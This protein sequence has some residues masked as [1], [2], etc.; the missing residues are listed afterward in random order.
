MSS[1]PLS[2]KVLAT[3][4]QAVL[5][6]FELVKFSDNP[7][8]PEIQVFLA[9][10]KHALYLVR[11]NLGGLYPSDDNGA[12][13]FAHIEHI[14]EDSR[15]ST[16]L[17]V[18]LTEG[19][20]STW[21]TKQLYISCEHRHIL[22]LHI[23]V[24]WS[25]DYTFRY[26]LP[27]HLHLSKHPLRRS[28]K[29]PQLRLKPFVGCRYANVQGYRFFMP[30]SFTDEENTGM[31]EDHHRQV[32]LHVDVHE[33][34]P[35]G[36]LEAADQDHIR[37]IALEYKQS[38][39]SKMN[40]VSMSRNALYHKR[41]NL[42]NDLCAW[43]GWEVCIKSDS[44]VMSSILLRRQYVPPLCDTAQDI[45]IQ[46]KCPRYVLDEGK[47]TE[48]ELMR[49]ASLI[50]DSFSASTAIFTQPQLVYQDFIQARLDALLYSED[51]LS[52]L[53]SSLSLKPAIEAEARVFTKSCLKVMA[54]ESQLPSPELVNA[55]GK[56]VDSKT[57]PLQV[58]QAVLERLPHLNPKEEPLPHDPV[59]NSWLARV[60]RYFA[61]CLDGVFLPSQFTLYDM[62]MSKLSNKPNKV[63]IQEALL[64]MLHIRP[65]DLT[66]P[67]K[68]L[69]I[70]QLLLTPGFFQDYQF[71]DLVMQATLELGW[72]AKQFAEPMG[73]E[74]LSLEFTVFLAKLLVSDMSSVNLKTAICR[75]I[76][77]SCSGPMHLSI[78][79]PAIMSILNQRNIHLKTYGTVTLV[80]M[81]AAHE[82]VKDLIL[83]MN[84]HHSLV[85]HLQFRDDDLVYYTLTLLANMSKTTTHRLILSQSGVVEH[86]TKLLTALPP[87]P[88]KHR[89]IAELAGTL[90]QFANDEDIWTKMTS[91]R[92]TFE[93]IQEL[94]LAAPPGTRMRSRIMFVLRQYCNR[95][96]N[97]S[98]KLREDVGQA[99]PVLV[100]DLHNLVESKKLSHGNSEA[101]DCAVNAVLLLST[102]SL[103]S[104]LCKE[105]RK[106]NFQPVLAKLRISPLYKLDATREKLGKLWTQLL[107][108]PKKDAEPGAT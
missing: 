2:L 65:K 92:H 49:N 45:V 103:S 104:Q 100:L 10:G 56:E 90:G 94:L 80:N 70:R 27:K 44:E 54:E 84:A 57:N 22:A 12:I 95:P 58:L 46:V 31:F 71:S 87:T 28:F 82:S 93:R 97:I 107:E 86:L 64:F 101:L 7:S 25:T 26:G 53:A 42:T 66:K 8:R 91:D 79:V 88:Q 77:S 41:M 15:N 60:A 85:Q 61:Y 21:G 69:E 96:N 68:P 89:L 51:A 14:S 33:S 63:K 73:E 62:C 48:D 76:T 106:A 16:D 50:A 30:S 37:W 43:T 3:R 35:L 32:E 74:R 99:I 20:S 29:R 78:L 19:G 17:C 55:L 59:A 24:S 1:D 108:E 105:M 5:R 67:W 102:L 75:S 83:T 81:T 47:V 52:W 72:L 34:V 11:R 9:I 13:Y 4:T 40:R 18:Y 39:T 98:A 36:N 23:Q 6:Y 38:V